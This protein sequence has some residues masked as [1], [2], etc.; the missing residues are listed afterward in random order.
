MHTFTDISPE[1]IDNALERS[2]QAFQTYRLLP[3]ARRAELLRAIAAELEDMGDAWLKTAQEETHLPEARL[4]TERART[5]FQLESYGLACAQ[6]DWMRVSID[7]ALPDRNPPR[8]DLRKMMIPLGPVVVFG[9]SN[10]PYAYSTA[11]G[12]TASALAAGCSIIVKAH[13]AHPQTSL[14]AAQA[15]QRAIQKTALPADLFQLVY[16]ASFEVG[17]KLVQH[18]R[19]AAVGFTGS[20]TGGKQLF[21]WAY[22][23]AHPIPVFAEMGSINP[24]FLLPER[25]QKEASSLAET[26]AAS[27]TLGVGQFCTN[28]GILVAT[29]GEGLAVFQTRLTELLKQTIPAAMLHSGIQR[30]YLEK[31][32]QLRQQPGVETHLPASEGAQGTATPQLTQVEAKK[33]LENHSLHQEVFGP[34][35]LLVVCSTTEELYEV[36]ACIEG[37]LTCTVFGSNQEL[38]KYQTL[39][40]Q[41][42]MHCG[43]LIFNSVPTGVEVVQSTHHG[44]PFPATTDSRFTAVGS[45]AILRFARPLC[46][47]NCPEELLPIELKS[48]NPL[49]LWRKVNGQWTNG[50]IG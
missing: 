24:I 28:P 27:V 15:I 26:I 20:Y 43:R 7:T 13:P 46:F 2:W 32:A 30:A 29:A 41:L 11:G 12:D 34:A 49:Q 1:Q 17:K 10:F 16:G 5:I 19:T 25:L 22:Q 31:S 8:A 44:G 14:L 35:T 45:D 42:R 18:P 9:A 48:D 37:Q 39:C 40:E 23:R 33:F 21:D 6:G 3:L 38:L 4:R 47:Q 36:A 50:S